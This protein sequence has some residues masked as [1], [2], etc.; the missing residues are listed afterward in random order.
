MSKQ[1]RPVGTYKVLREKLGLSQREM[2]ER[3]GVSTSTYRRYERGAPISDP[4]V[5]NRLRELAERG[6]ETMIGRDEAPAD[7][8]R[9]PFSSSKILAHAGSLAHWVEDPWRTAPIIAE[10]H[11]TNRCSHACPDCTFRHT[12]FADRATSHLEMPRDVAERL[13]RELAEMGTKAIMWGGGG[14]PTVYPHA[15]EM[16]RLAG[17]LGLGQGIV[18]N[19]SRMDEETA[20]VFAESFQW[21]RVSLNAAT[22]E[23][24]Y[25]IHRAR[26]FDRVRSGLRLLV[27]TRN[28]TK[29]SP[30]TLGTSFLLSEHNAAEV[31]E[32]AEFAK[33]A[34]VD[35]FQV[36]PVIVQKRQDRARRFKR[37][38]TDKL[39]ADLTTV[40]AMASPGFDVWIPDFKFADIMGEDIGK[41]FAQ[42]WGASFYACV[43]ANCDLVVCCLMLGESDAFV[44]GNVRSRS[45]RSVWESEK[46]RRVVCGVDV[47]ACPPN[48]RL[49]ETNR[50]LDMILSSQDVKHPDFLN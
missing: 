10:I 30:L 40:R 45:F 27:E 46:R 14:E 47:D 2:A 12:L 35:Y 29:Q 26:D 43:T 25:K 38:W 3:I 24:H 50:M 22:P 13:V 6:S 7:H 17:D 11:L 9:S 8:V 39:R 18:T 31:V 15:K 41:P 23:T 1:R 33:S 42:C 4:Q 5:L 21:V 20:A 32:A 44:F 36:K 16:F 19:G 34:D 48:C 28:R 37:M 49:A